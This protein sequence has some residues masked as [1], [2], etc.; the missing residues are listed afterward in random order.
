MLAFIAAHEIANIVMKHS[1]AR[2]REGETKE[3]LKMRHEFEADNVGLH[4]MARA[5]YDPTGA[6]EWAKYSIRAEK[7]YKK[8]H[9]SKS[10]S[11]ESGLIPK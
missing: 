2:P 7:L 3:E 4:M 9:P 8:T 1:T 11:L 5:G 6:I 10:S